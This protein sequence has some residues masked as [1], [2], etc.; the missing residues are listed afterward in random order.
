MPNC[1][2]CGKE[3]CYHSKLHVW[4][5]DAGWHW[6]CLECGDNGKGTHGITYF[7]PMYE[8][9]VVN[10]NTHEW[11]GFDACKECSEKSIALEARC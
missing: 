2:V 7:V 6:E 4:C 10:P 9:R 3:L 11:A 1:A 8:G 5:D